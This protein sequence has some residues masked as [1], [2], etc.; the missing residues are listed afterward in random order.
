M[1]SRASPRWARIQHAGGAAEYAGYRSEREFLAAVSDGQM[2]PPSF[3]LRGRTVWD[4]LDL[5]ASID[6][7]KATAAMP[8]RWQER[9]PDRV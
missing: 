5:D 9:A 4:I 3:E 7:M 1:A 6:A 8:K 2:P